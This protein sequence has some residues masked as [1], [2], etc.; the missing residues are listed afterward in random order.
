MPGRDRDGPPAGSPVGDW[1]H[2]STSRTPLRR[3][4]R[5]PDDEP[6]AR[7]RREGRPVDTWGPGL[8]AR[9]RAAVRAVVIA[10]VREDA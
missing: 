6:A 2:P 3:R 7:P 1:A 5:L 4:P 10:A 9:R 8:A